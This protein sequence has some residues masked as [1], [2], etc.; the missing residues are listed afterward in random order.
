MST[1]DTGR[2]RLS[3]VERRH[4]IEEAAT[5]VFA[6]RGYHGGSMD[7]IARRAGVTPPVVYDH[8]E[9]KQHLHLHLVEL[10]FGK[11]REIWSTHMAGP[12][13]GVEFPRAI[14]AWFE[15]VEQH[16]Y[17]SRMLFRD[18][19]G[20]PAVQA[21]HQ[22]IADESKAALLPLVAARLDAEVDAVRI[23]VELGWEALRAVLQGL[24]MWWYDHP[25]VPRERLVRGALNATWHGFERLLASLP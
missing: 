24:A 16:P 1:S 20:D 15:Y 25:D 8:F 12:D 7:E 11:L 14:D 4:V 9:S 5:S 19:T 23:D 21:A 22:R 17:A 18:T 2:R 10:H 6:E 3:A 13:I